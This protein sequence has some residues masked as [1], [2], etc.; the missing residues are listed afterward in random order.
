MTHLRE[1]VWRTQPE[2]ATDPFTQLQGPRLTGAAC[3]GVDPEA[4]FPDKCGESHLARRICTNC[5]VVAEC[6]EWALEHY[7]MGIWGGTSFKERA[8]IRKR[9]RRAA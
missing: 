4:F 1:P 9:R 5:P 2:T 6:L 8:E 3:A 7:E